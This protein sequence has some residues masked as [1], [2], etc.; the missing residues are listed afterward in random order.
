MALPG[1]DRE[2]GAA[3]VE[4]AGL[5]A[6]IALLMIAAVSAFAAGPPR[7]GGRA[8]GATIARR[9]ACAP[10]LPDAC[11]HHPLVRAYG[12]PLARL[13]RALAP[14]PAARLGPGGLPLMPV[15]FRYCRQPSCAV[16]RPGPEGL[17]LTTSGRRTTVFTS[18]DDQRHSRGYVELS[19]W[20]YRPGL[21][22]EREIR[23]ATP[24]DV[25]AASGT[26]VLL[27]DDPNLVPLETLPGR[28]QYR[29]P[30]GERPPWQWRVP[31]I[32]P[33]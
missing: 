21:G 8:I 1:N 14:Q 32:Y 7:D 31:G 10:R 33:G 20:L 9:M 6:L 4:Q 22:W 17:H 30:P 25:A 16:P 3:S 28:D 12:W 26:A 2:R 18:I 23:R 13:A 19:Y 11:R 24:A 15:D 29:F 27:R 5:V